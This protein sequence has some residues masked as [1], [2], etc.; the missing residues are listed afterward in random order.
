MPIYGVFVN[1]WTSEHLTGLETAKK[2]KCGKCQLKVF[3][4]CDPTT[5]NPYRNEMP[6]AYYMPDLL[7]S[8][9]IQQKI[10]LMIKGDHTRTERGKSEHDSAA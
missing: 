7:N 1:M 6:C 2:R 5:I 4:S 9:S 10:H 3:C 8:H